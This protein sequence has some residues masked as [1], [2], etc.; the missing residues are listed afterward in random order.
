[1]TQKIYKRKLV[2]LLTLIAVLALVCL[3]TVIFDPERAARRSAVFVWMEPRLVDQADS[4][5][6]YGSLGYL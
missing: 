6:I 2:C 5:E 4:I 1:M 3:G